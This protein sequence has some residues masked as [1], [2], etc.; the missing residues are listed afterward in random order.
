MSARRSAAG[1]REVAHAVLGLGYM[2]EVHVAALAKLRARGIACRLAGVCDRDARRLDGRVRA[3]GNLVARRGA[4]RLFDPA[5]VHTTTD[6]A[7]LLADPAI[8]S[9]SICTTTSSHVELAHAALAAGKHV[10]VEKPV[11][12]E[13]RAIESLEAAARRAR[14]LVMPAMC[15]R[16][17]PG[18]SWLQA[19]VARGTFGAVRSAVFQR[20]ASPPAWSREFY[21]DTRAS[22]GALFD[23]HVHDADFVHWLFG[24]P[25]AVSSAGS[26][27]HVTTLYHFARGPGHVVAEGGWDHTPGFAFT[28]RY[29]VVFE[30]ATAD[31]DLSRADVLRVSRGGRSTPVALPP[32]DGYEGELAHFLGAVARG[33]PGIEPSLAE[34][35]AV[36]RTLDAERVSAARGRS[37]ACRARR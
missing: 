2:G 24:A 28:M 31:F 9:V 22:G 15:M 6:A 34:A 8:D 12:L 1:A 26:A 30:R 17:W 14:R 16:F 7:E 25:A 13:V 35:A 32:G 21:G 27:E 4:K 23:L 37:V 5:R 19:R 36:T 18:W 11:A 10:L 20:L 33:A 3:S 29:V